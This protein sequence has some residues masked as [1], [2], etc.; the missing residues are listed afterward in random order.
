MANVTTTNRK[1]R[2]IYQELPESSSVHKSS[3]EQN[4]LKTVTTTKTDKKLVP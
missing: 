1:S 3:F 4:S 2:S